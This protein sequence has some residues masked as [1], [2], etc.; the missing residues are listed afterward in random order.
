MRFLPYTLLPL[1]LV[2]CGSSAKSH[3]TKPVDLKPVGNAVEFFSI[4]MVVAVIVVALTA[5]I[6]A[7]RG[8]DDR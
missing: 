6:L 7:A 5:I 4:C 2:S 3:T 1:L 8:G